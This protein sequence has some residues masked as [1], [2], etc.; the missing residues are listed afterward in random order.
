M[1]GTDNTAAI[2]DILER[3]NL[4]VVPLDETRHWFRYHKLFAQVLRSRL[5]RIE[6][7]MVLTLHERASAWYQAAELAGEAIDHALTAGDVRRAVDLIASNW[8]QY[9]TAGRA[10]TVLGW[11]RSLSDEQIAAS[12][13]AAHCAAW[14]AA[15]SEEP[16]A[17]RRWIPAI[18]AGGRHGPLPDGISSFDPRPRC[19]AASTASTAF[20]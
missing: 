9:V 11:M 3:E 16:E 14:A 13:L 2:I 6:P 5:A 1:A 8:H 4:F 19:C 20:A 7:E 12:P 15:H 17:L 18:E 10:G